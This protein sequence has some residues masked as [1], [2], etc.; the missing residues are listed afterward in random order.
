MAEA[1]EQETAKIAGANIR[2]AFNV[3]GKERVMPGG[4]EA[5]ILRIRQEALANVLKHANAS[6]VTGNHG[7]QK[8]SGRTDSNRQRHRF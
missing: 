6:L 7:L 3:K 4:V 5:A 1:L 8:N 2:T